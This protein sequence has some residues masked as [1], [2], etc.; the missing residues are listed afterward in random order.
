LLRGA[1]SSPTILPR[2]SGLKVRSMHPTARFASLALAFVAA[3]CSSDKPRTPTT[4]PLNEDARPV[5]MPDPAP[6]AIRPAPAPTKTEPHEVPEPR[7]SSESAAPGAPEVAHREPDAGGD[8]APTE[9][10]R[11]ADS[12]AT[13]AESGLQRA[14]REALAAGDYERALPLVQELWAQPIEERASQL[15]AAGAFDEA[16]ALLA[17][18]LA[19]VPS[20]AEL[21]ELSAEAEL[22]LGRARNDRALVE[23]ALASFE[24]LGQVPAGSFGASRAARALGRSDEALARARTGWALPGSALFAARVTPAWSEPPERTL[25]EA[26]AMVYRAQPR[27]PA[28][29]KAR[30]LTETEDALSRAMARG[31]DDAWAWATLATLYLEARRPYDALQA[32]ERG[33][34]KHP[35]SDE[36]GTLVAR[37]G[38]DVDGG[39]GLFDAFAR[40]QDRHPNA[41]L[42][43]W[44]PAVER[45]A[46]V[47][48]GRATEAPETA[49]ERAER[50]FRACRGLDPRYTDACVEYEILCRNAL[51]WAQLKREQTAEALASFLSMEDLAPGGL[52]HEWEG[53]LAS[54]VQGIANIAE[55]CRARGDLLGVAGA[56]EALAKY[57]PRNVEWMRACAIE[58]R[59]AARHYDEEGK[60]FDK[61]ARGQLDKAELER[62]RELANTK[63]PERDSELEEKRYIRKARDRHE[64]AKQLFEKSYRAFVAAARL[65]PEDVRLANDAAQIAIFYL[66]P[67]AAELEPLLLETV[68]RATL[69]LDSGDTSESERIALRTAIGDAH[70]NLGQLYMAAN[71]ALALE[72]FE[73]AVDIGPDPRPNVKEQLIPRCRRAIQAGFTP[74]TSSSPSPPDRR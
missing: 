74:P 30:L 4:P 71:P 58:H 37:A 56:F 41:A 51:G 73:K 63:F 47:A 21:V 39:R 53:R 22:A 1:R 68:R 54:G 6:P 20:R 16:H 57:E 14:A 64:L 18:A 34:D 32:A 29:A 36:L 45:L 43:Q 49:L 69:Q 67:D 65:A 35:A 70:V 8:R 13:A 5:A 42:G 40:F 25:A 12:P 11:T 38:R 7:V 60:L 61:A 31:G 3:A 10:A 15:M 66:T 72:C 46:I 52:R 2:R 23:R 27:E 9:P 28:D 62:A 24:S 55:V 19:R 50:G 48:A 44:F 17:S 33:F 26:C 59:D